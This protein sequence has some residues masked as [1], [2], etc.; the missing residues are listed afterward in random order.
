[1]TTLSTS[2]LKTIPP[3]GVAITAFGTALLDFSCD[4]CQSP[5]R[6][7]LLDVCLPE[8]HA[9]GLTTFTV[10]AG[11][12]G[13][14]GY[15]IGGI[16]WESLVPHLSLGGHV[17]TVFSIVLFFYIVCA[18]VTLTSFREIPLDD[19]RGGQCERAQRK[20]KKHSRKRS[21]VDY[22][23]FTNDPDLD[24][25]TSGSDDDDDS[26]IGDKEDVRSDG[27]KKTQDINLQQLASSQ[28][29]TLK[30]G[31]NSSDVYGSFDVRAKT[32]REV[33][34]G[35]TTADASMGDTGQQQ[36]ASQQSVVTMPTTDAAELSSTISVWSYLVSK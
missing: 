3:W 35:T 21:D 4:T 36:A 19:L 15:I 10:M 5:C 23:K 28:T 27:R 34:S 24:D 9:P 12:G 29:S 17:R 26:D 14:L 30:D 31:L 20:K 11:L 13:S 18:C 32:E 25:V 8:D 6:T 22:Q 33:Q 16:D 7:F 2:I 1:M